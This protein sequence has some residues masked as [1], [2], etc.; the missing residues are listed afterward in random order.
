M[1]SWE[2]LNF[3]DEVSNLG[4]PFCHRPNASHAVADVWVGECLR[5]FNDRQT[6]TFKRVKIAKFGAENDMN[7]LRRWDVEENRMI[8]FPADEKVQLPVP[9][10][11]D[12]SAFVRNEVSLGSWVRSNKRRASDH[13]QQQAPAPVPRSIDITVGDL[14][15]YA[16]TVEASAVALF[17]TRWSKILFIPSGG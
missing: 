3:D 7:P 16:T 9:A 1:R 17:I 6:S 15:Y 10:G 2:Q 4:F 8:D 13:V 14:F 12:A 11:V 5:C